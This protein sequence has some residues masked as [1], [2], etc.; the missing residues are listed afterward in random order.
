[1]SHN[2]VMK[3]R[4]YQ[5]H[6]IPS[7]WSNFLMDLST[8]THRHLS[9]SFHGLKNSGY[10]I[11]FSTRSW[12]VVWMKCPASLALE[13][14]IVF[15]IL[16]KT[17]FAIW[18]K[19]H[20][21]LTFKLT[22]SLWSL[23]LS[24]ITLFRNISLKIASDGSYHII[25]K[26]PRILNANPRLIW[27]RCYLGNHLLHCIHSWWDNLSH[28]TGWF[29]AITSFHGSISLISL[30][31]KILTSVLGSQASVKKGPIFCSMQN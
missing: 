11:P 27:A 17:Y 20:T 25:M 19:S 13:Q 6:I 23:S 31:C 24:Y 22:A 4:F 26:F 29:S 9:W 30:L 15:K 1:M 28:T 16:L 5:W 2:L 8:P 3:S 18:Q 7:S 12:V 21:K 10:D 14:R